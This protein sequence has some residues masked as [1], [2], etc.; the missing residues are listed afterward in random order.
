MTETAADRETLP[1]A[2]DWFLNRT[3]AGDIDSVLATL[4]SDAAIIHAGEE[5]RNEIIS[6]FISSPWFIAGYINL[7]VTSWT[8]ND[9]RWRVLVDMAGRY[10]DLVAASGPFVFDFGLDGSGRIARLVVTADL[11]RR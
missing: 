6:E 5:I 8:H 9:D 11:R 3:N 4:S 7:Q 10:E 1:W 2:V